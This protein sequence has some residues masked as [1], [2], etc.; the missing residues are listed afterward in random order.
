MV[1][2]LCYNDYVGNSEFARLKRFEIITKVF[3]GLM[4]FNIVVVILLFLAFG[5]RWIIERNDPLA[6]GAGMVMALVYWGPIVIINMIALTCLLILSIIM[7]CRKNINPGMVIK[8]YK[9][10]A[11]TFGIELIISLVAMVCTFY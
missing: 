6:G 3:N 2:F 5:I 8:L 7:A 9:K 11:A 1:N 4:Y 10:S